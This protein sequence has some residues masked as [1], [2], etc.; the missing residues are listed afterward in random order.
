MTYIQSNTTN[1]AYRFAVIFLI[2]TIVLVAV[3]LIMIYSHTVS[4]AN[5][6]K[7]TKLALKTTMTESA[8]AQS[9]IFKSATDTFLRSK[10]S[11]L[12]L[13]EEKN[14]TYFELQKQWLFAS[15]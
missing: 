3:Y 8:E 12:G 5:E 4:L 11:E 7:K 15:Q 13:V 1:F 14:P 6:I 10:A 9:E 2:S